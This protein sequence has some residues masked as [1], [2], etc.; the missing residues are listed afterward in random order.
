M[1]KKTVALLLALTLAVGVVAGGTVA[2]LLDKT[3]T[4]TNTFTV[5]DV[6]VTLTETV[7]TDNKAE[8][9]MIP[10]TSYEKDPKVT[11]EANSVDC[12]L[13]V[14]FDEVNNPGTYLTYKSTLKGPD[15]TL[16]EGVKD[17]NGD[18]VNVWYRT[19][20]ATDETKSWDLL[21]KLDASDDEHNYTVKVKDTVVKAGTNTDGT[22]N[23]AMPA[24]TAQPVLKYQAAAVQQDNLL[25]EEAWNLVADDMGCQAVTVPTT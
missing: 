8:F 7:A 14:R 2:W 3:D 15:W 12:Y 4:V 16:L 19:V 22:Q 17:K 18:H 21:E 25:V 11:V 1:K 23:V 20:G 13:F 9:Q 6:G 5:G 24:S 10:G